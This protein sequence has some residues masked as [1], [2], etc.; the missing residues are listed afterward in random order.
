MVEISY[1]CRLG[2]LQ[3]T[4]WKAK[5]NIE[6]CGIGE[7]FKLVEEEAGTWWTPCRQHPCLA[8]PKW[9]GS[10]DQKVPSA[11][12]YEQL[13]WGLRL[14]RESID[15]SRNKP[16]PGIPVTVPSSAALSSI[17]AAPRFLKAVDS[18]SSTDRVF[19]VHAL[20]SLGNEP[21]FHRKHSDWVLNRAQRF[22]PSSMLQ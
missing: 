20:P 8:H 16:K 15:C 1:S 7:L 2:A 9:I 11:N 17:K 14:S 18:T 19:D 10:R 12:K 6:D 4:N 21:S 5:K 13:P 22:V 3:S